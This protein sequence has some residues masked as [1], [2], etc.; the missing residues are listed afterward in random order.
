MGI[1]HTL[2]IIVSVIIIVLL[3]AFLAMVGLMIGL[4]VIL[5]RLAKKFERASDDIAG[6]IR[7]LA[8][9]SA[10]A[11]VSGL[12]ASGVKYWHKRGRRE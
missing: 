7:S 8:K 12:L 2:F 1:D 11:I 3:V 4:V 10:P 6:T 5:R 9:K